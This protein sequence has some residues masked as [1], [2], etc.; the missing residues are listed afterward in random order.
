MKL[1]KLRR[2]NDS[3][4]EE[5]EP[6]VLKPVQAFDYAM[7]VL[8]N[9]PTDILD[10]EERKHFAILSKTLHSFE[11]NL[12]CGLSIEDKIEVADAMSD[13]TEYLQTSMIVLEQTFQRSMMNRYE[14][15]NIRNAICKLYLISTIAQ[16]IK[17]NL[18]YLRQVKVLC[19]FADWC[20]TIV[21]RTLRIQNSLDK[22]AGKDKSLYDPNS[23]YEIE[24]AVKGFVNKYFDYGKAS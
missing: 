8:A 12:F 21:Y 24:L 14:D 22:R 13:F 5:C 6:V 23:S 3:T 15:S 9:F 10:K 1:F 17:M 16:S 7:E 20:D 2:N 18:E 11:V 4:W 19:V